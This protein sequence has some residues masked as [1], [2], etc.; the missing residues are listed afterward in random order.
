MA[1][2][3]VTQVTRQLALIVAFGLANATAITLGKVLGEGKEELAK[4]YAKR[5]I[6]LTI[7]VGVIGVFIII[8]ASQ[9]ARVTLSLSGEARSY[10]NLMMIVMSYFALCQAYN[11]TLVVGVFRA[12]GDTNFGLILDTVFMWGSSI[13]LGAIAAFVLKWPIPVVYIILMSDEVIKIPITTWRYR[14]MIWVKNITR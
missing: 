3:S 11:T 8:L 13:L 2:N 1:A 6:R 7:L 12:G 5:F 9:V 14:S 4:V 10:L